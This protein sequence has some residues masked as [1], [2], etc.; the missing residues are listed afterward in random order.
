MSLLCL[1]F[2]VDPVLLHL[3]QQEIKFLQ[4]DVNNVSV[5]FD[6][7]KIKVQQE[8]PNAAWFASLEIRPAQVEEQ[9]CSLK[10]IY[11]IKIL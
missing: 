9:V 5:E 7:D 4:D 2:P 11:D 8:L 6:Q 1:S 10:G 3:V